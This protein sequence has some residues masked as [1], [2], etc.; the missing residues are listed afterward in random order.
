M[1]C[2][3]NR[4]YDDTMIIE[5]ILYSNNPSL[6]FLDFYTL[7]LCVLFFSITTGFTCVSSEARNIGCNPWLGVSMCD[8]NISYPNLLFYIF[9]VFPISLHVLYEFHFHDFH[10]NFN[11]F[12]DV[13]WRDKCRFK[14][15]MFSVNIVW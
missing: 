9:Y 4:K 14:G 11:F 10:M 8:S 5:M 15:L 6:L 13:L 1:S 7:L 12:Y 2:S 3:N